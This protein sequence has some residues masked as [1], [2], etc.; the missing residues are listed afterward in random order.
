MSDSVTPWTAALKVPL[1]STISR[2][3]LKFVCIESVIVGEEQIRQDG[4]VRLSHL[5]ASCIRL[6]FYK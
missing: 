1:S 6:M 3:L 4:M 2:N 5:T